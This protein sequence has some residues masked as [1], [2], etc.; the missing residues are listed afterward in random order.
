MDRNLRDGETIRLVCLAV[1]MESSTSKWESLTPEEVYE[2]KERFWDLADTTMSEFQCFGGSWWGDGKNFFFIGEDI[3]NLA[4]MAFKASYRLLERVLAELYLSLGINLHLTLH[5]GLAFYNKDPGKIT[6]RA[7]DICGK[8]KETSPAGSIV[9]SENLYLQLP[10]KEQKQFVYLGTGKKAYIP[11]YIF[12]KANIQFVKPELLFLPDED[13]FALWDSWHKTFLRTYQQLDTIGI[14]QFQTLVRPEI[15]DVFVQ[16]NAAEKGI[17]SKEELQNEALYLEEQ[18]KD[19]KEADS[20][21]L[22][23]R[24]EFLKR[25]ISRDYISEGMPVPITRLLP[26]YQRLIVLGEPG[27]GK[28]TLLKWLGLNW[29]NHFALF[30]KELPSGRQLP[31]FVRL[32]T[33]G[34]EHQKALNEGKSLSFHEFLGGYIED[35][36]FKDI[37]KRLDELLEKGL[38]LLLLDGIDELSL[39]LQTK[40][41]LPAIEGFVY[42]FPKNRVMITSRIVG[43]EPLNLGEDMGICTLVP[44]NQEQIKDF[45]NR[46]CLAF[47]KALSP[48]T[49]T[50]YLIAAGQRQTQSL[51]KQ[52]EDN[53]AIASLITNPLMLT[54]LALIN[55][56]G[57]SLPEHRVEFYS[58]CITTLLDIW[59]KERGGRN[60]T[61]KERQVCLYLALWMQEEECYI[62][63]ESEVLKFFSERLEGEEAGKELLRQL[64]DSRGILCERGAGWIGFLHRS[65]QDYLA[66][67][68]I[69]IK[70]E[71]EEYGIRYRR[72]PQWRELIR[73]LTAHIAIEQVQIEDADALVRK[74]GMLDERDKLE[75]M[76]KL[77]LF[78]A[79]WCI[80]DDIGISQKTRKEI[81]EGCIKAITEKRFP[82]LYE[83]FKNLIGVVRDKYIKEFLREALLGLLKDKDS[84]VREV[85]AYSL[86]SIAGDE[87]VKEALLGLLRDENSVVRRATEFSLR[88]IAG[89]EQVKEALLGFLKDEDWGV[90]GA[91]VFSLRSIAG[92]EQVKEALLVFLKDEDSNMRRTAASSL[93]SIAGDEQVREALLGLLKDEDWWVRE[94]CINALSKIAEQEEI[95]DRLC[96]CLNDP[97][98]LVRNAAFKAIARFAYIKDRKYMEITKRLDI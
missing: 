9:I 14:L 33:Y 93:R 37:Q 43:F 56:Q 12:P 96:Q 47:E 40:S 76:T 10:E 90:R 69:Y 75:D 22:N 8:M 97:I 51:I 20:Q 5:C 68:S 72:H 86:R 16:P 29:R 6:G 89:D 50:K 54:I 39:A 17:Y 46:Y 15:K 80:A 23:R 82:A 61:P 64:K 45:L 66:V 41:V 31:V 78:T 42:T 62:V 52:I 70:K 38:I 95:F 19:K 4:L 67:K 73:L 18:L 83:D 24:L 26:K 34:D 30:K 32:K 87:Q 94:I 79:A 91:A 88:S 84:W 71:A 98:L 7:V 74:I 60:L 65:L 57:I 28:T 63:R 85:A 27:S 81:A 35:Q 25:E 36:G 92:D 21:R 2:Q 49:E 11:L 48:H 77:A 13:P 58:R 53:T 59:Y 3:E 44:F 1:D 55:R